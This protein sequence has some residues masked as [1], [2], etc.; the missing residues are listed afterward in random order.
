MLRRS[1]L[2]EQSLKRVFMRKTLRALLLL[3]IIVLGVLRFANTS[4]YPSVSATYVE[5]PIS[6][7][8]TWTLADS[9][10]VVTKDIV[11]NPGVTL[12][13]MPRVEVRFGGFFCLT[14]EG[15]LSASGTLDK[16][17]TFTSNKIQPQK[18]DWNTIKF[19]SAQKSTI[20][21]SFLSYATN[22]LSIENGNVDIQYC[23]I[24]NNLQSGIYATGENQA[25]IRGNTLQSNQNGILV[26]GN[27]TG[28]DI[29]D[30]EVF[31]N[32]QSGIYLHAYALAEAK[33]DFDQARASI[34]I[35]GV[36]IYGNNVSHNQNGIYLHSDAVANASVYYET[37]AFADASI[38]NVTVSNNMVMLNTASGI[39]LYSQTTEWLYP[40][41]RWVA[42][43]D[44]NASTNATILGNNL[45]ANLKGIY[46]SG[47]ATA[48]VTRNSVSY[49]TYGVFFEQARDNAANYND[50]YGNAYGM[51]VSAEASANA[52]HNY[53]GDT[54]GPYH[55]SL[56]P[57]GEGNPVNGDGVNLDFIP[58][59]PAPNGDVNERPVARLVAD[60]NT[61]ALNQVVTFDASTS[62]D[63]RRIDKYFFNFGD[64][65]T[66][67][68]T[69]LSV[70]VHNYSL[71]GVV[72]VSLAVMDG[73]G[74][75]SNNDAK[76][77]ITIQQIPSLNVS[78]SMSRSSIGSKGEVSIRVHVANG[79]LAVEDASVRLVSD[80]GGNFTPS[81]SGQTNSTGDFAVTFT[82]PDL[83]EQTNVRITATAS[84]SGFADGSDSKYLEVLPPGAHTLG[85]EVFA[86][87]TTIEALATSPVTV[88]VYYELSVIAGAIVALSSD[89][90]S[91]SAETGY[92]DSNGAFR[93]NFT[94]PQTT[95]K[96]N[97]TITA[98]AAKSGY[99]DGVGQ[100]KITVI[101][102]VSGNP[103]T[104]A[105]SGLSLITIL[106]IFGGIVAVIIVVVLLLKRR[107]TVAITPQR[108]IPSSPKSAYR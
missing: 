28:V 65:E 34:L 31:S 94:A 99:L 108:S 30:N 17:I 64:G 21:Y 13:I 73:F 16:P 20:T 89:S 8:T 49:G 107:K 36:F 32:S 52:E 80:K 59:L 3:A 10:Y 87:S 102:E 70:V 103:D 38:Y 61:V 7:D 100:T 55:I 98:T 2:R 24:S 54:S 92:T 47:R 41:R 33:R 37:S 42:Y 84:K 76:I 71:I 25:L 29:S 66:S 88:N 72:E 50:I 51:N 97:V 79:T 14:V 22:A 101:P 106:S 105:S 91:F 83:A 96:I 81:S 5:G 39:R 1:F 95:T 104:G 6:Q 63:D 43:A 60:K 75:T 58:F 77:A 18:G 69:T 53:W 62:S 93:C 35:H 45:S 48:N 68:W 27:S 74:V 26:T 46:V 67:D 23:Q 85:V 56:N 44:A 82:A 57:E 40:F 90:G 19:K 9:P 86:S 15:I 4:L 78:L 12:T 11:V